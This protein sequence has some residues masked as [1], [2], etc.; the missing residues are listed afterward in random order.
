MARSALASAA[1]Q[2]AVKSVSHREI[3]VGAP[4]G[5]RVIEGYIDLLVETPD[6]LVIVDYKTDTAATEADVDAKLAAYE[7]QAPPTRWRSRCPPRCRWSTAAS[8]SA[9]RPAPSNGA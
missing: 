6:G 2:L 9:A 7:L 4:V 1:V 8:Y 3:Y 5:D